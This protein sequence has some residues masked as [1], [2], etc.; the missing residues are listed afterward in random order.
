MPP[1]EEPKITHGLLARKL[2]RVAGN[3]LAE[4][5]ERARKAREDKK[6]SAQLH[7]LSFSAVSRETG[8]CFTATATPSR[9]GKIVVN[10]SEE[11]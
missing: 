11:L 10:K 7:V 2:A 9:M 4:L 8:Y 6:L 3:E 5:G 1:S